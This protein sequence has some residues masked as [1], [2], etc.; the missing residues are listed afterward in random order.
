M[1]GVELSQAIKTQILTS[2]FMGINRLLAVLLKS[3]NYNKSMLHV[4]IA[5]HSGKDLGILAV[6]SDFL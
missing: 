5:M 4:Y 3:C 2:N 1:S 6:V